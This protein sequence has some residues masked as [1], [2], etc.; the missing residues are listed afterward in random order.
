MQKFETPKAEVIEFDIKD[1]ITTSGQTGGGI[2]IDPCWDGG[3][4]SDCN[5]HIIEF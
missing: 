4:G 1:V 3:C 2:I 5:E